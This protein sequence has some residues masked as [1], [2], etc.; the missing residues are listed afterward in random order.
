MVVLSRL[1]ALLAVVA[2]G[3]CRWEDDD[4]PVG[5]FINDL[6]LHVTPRPSEQGERVVFFVQGE[7]PV[8]LRAHR[9]ADLLTLD[10]EPLYR[11]DAEGPGSEAPR[12]L[13]YPLP[14]DYEAPAGLDAL[15]TRQTVQLPADIAPG[16]YILQTDIVG[17]GRSSDRHGTPSWKL[18]IVSRRD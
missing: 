9:Y 1:L 4:Y 8:K 11:L 6:Y 18:P 13:R 17:V 12:P 14:P 7:P 15:P 3:G 2:I 10:G 16:K 5:Q